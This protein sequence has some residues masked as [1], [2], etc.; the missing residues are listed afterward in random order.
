MNKSRKSNTKSVH[1]EKRVRVKLTKIIFFLFLL[2]GSIAAVMVFSPLL[3]LSDI[4]VNETTNYTTGQIIDATGIKH[5]E[6]AINHLGG[7]IPHLLNLRMGIAE[8]ELEKLPYVKTATIEY[9]FPKTIY[10]TVT[11]RNAIAWIRYSGNYLLVDEEGHVLEVDTAF[12]GEHPEIRGVQLDKFALGEKI[13]TKKPEKI[14]WIVQ[15]LQSLN[16]VDIDSTQKLTDVLDWVDI[17]E[18]R[19]LYMSLDERITAKIKINDQ[20]TYRLSYLKELYYNHIK[21]EEKGMVDFYDDKYAR[22]IAE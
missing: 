11:E 6:N 22:F 9:E 21:P 12:D 18:N 4:Y 17:L 1:K 7:S 16:S 2:V 8:K 14:T 3:L 19:E 15:L 10:I 20:L 13:Q 5:G